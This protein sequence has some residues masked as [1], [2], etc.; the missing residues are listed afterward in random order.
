MAPKFDDTHIGLHCV[1]EKEP[2][3]TH[4]DV[5]LMTIP[6]CHGVSKWVSTFY[7]ALEHTVSHVALQNHKNEAR[8]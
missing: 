8:D 7:S 5:K 2:L 1:S 4:L 3:I 6:K